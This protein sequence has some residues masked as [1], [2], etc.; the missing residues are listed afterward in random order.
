MDRFDKMVARFFSIALGLFLH[1]WVAGGS[2]L[3]AQ[4]PPGEDWR[5]LD[6]PHFRVTFPEGLLPLAQRAAARA[7]TAWEAL[8]EEFLEAPDGTI[9]LLL[10]DHIDVSNGFTQIFPSNR[11]VI[12]A[13]PPV[14]GFGLP[15]MDEWL[16]LVITH[17]LAHVFHEDRVR[18]LGSILRT[19]MGRVPLEW[20]FFPGAATPGWVVEGLATYY[21]SALTDAGRVRGSFH[22][23]VVRTAILENKFE[24]IDQSSGDSPEW[25]GG[26]RY[27]VYGSLFLTHLMD[28]F[29]PETM[30]VFADAVAGQWIPYRLNAAAQEAFGIPFTQAWDEWEA[31]LQERY[32]DL[33]RSLESQAPLTFGEALTDEGYYAWSP[34]PNPQGSGFAFAR[35][36][37]RSDS[38]VRFRDRATGRETKLVRTN[39]LSQ[40]S[41]TPSGELLF[42]QLEFTDSYRIR[43]DLF[44]RDRTGAV[45]QLTKGQR[46]DH[47]DVA[48]DGTRAVAVQEG[49][50]TNRL[51]LV[52]L[53]TGEVQPL[54]DFQEQVLW[55]YPRWS[56]D[57]K[58]LA[59][60][61]WKAGAYF[62]LVILSPD[63]TIQTEVTTD[64]AIDNGAAWSPDGRWLLWSSDRTGI[65][66]LFAVSIPGQGGGP[67]PVRQVTNVLGGAAY[68]S[69]DSEGR[70]IYFSAYHADGWRIERIPFDPGAWFDPFAL[71]AAFDTRPS[72]SRLEARAEGEARP[73]SPL[74]TLRPTFWAPTFREGD[75]AG[76][77]RVL[78]PG[79]GIFT[80]GE[81]LVGR[82]RYSASA[83][84]AG[85]EGSLNGRFSYAYGGLE[86]PVLSIAAAQSHDAGSRPLGGITEAGDTVPLFLVERE[87]ALGIGAAF[88]RKRTRNETVLSLSASHVWESRFLLENDLRRSSRFA[89]HRSEVRLGEARA[90]LSFGTARRF[91]LS[92]S[93]EDGIGLVIRGRLRR[94]LTLTD[95][96]RDVRGWDRSYQ[97]VVAQFVAFKGIPGPGFGN[98]VLALRGA[99]GLA[100]GPG[101]DAFHFETGGASG[102]TMPI[103]FV[104]VGQSLLFPIRGYETASRFGRRA[105]TV[106]AE[107]RFPLAMLNRGAGLFPLHLDWMA[108][109][110]FFDAGN[111]WGPDLSVA[112]F[113]N[114]K[115]DA[116]ASVGGEVVVRVLPL[117]FQSLDLRLGLARPLVEADE[118]TAYLRLGL[119]F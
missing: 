47:P 46:L 8:S 112:G 7:E 6:T 60:S 72:V 117:W 51:V 57:G 56:P 28:R 1:F 37:G 98:H 45:R 29:G 93:P 85:G 88:F 52:S 66:N 9:D 34:E 119:S 41:W 77:V 95:S 70:W 16:E 15:H 99:A 102:S 12:Y 106:A 83:T 100:G 78:E 2:A 76:D 19:L 116:L 105:W 14:D 30:G 54:I 115:R 10:T 80:S 23:M 107:Y 75:H 90:T 89:L 111:A 25:P 79:Y 114:P 110:L 61:R 24:R 22:E 59:V 27:Y 21:E 44:L 109:T 33:R 74:P 63:G 73:Y 36:D 94:D 86:N 35:Q 108:G 62:D 26:Q 50:G 97:D 104:D 4:V 87:R 65:P 5:T 68:P 11:I 31:E 101:A 53:S 82:H 48:P 38:Q 55:A 118:P 39:N 113:Q 3:E 96:L 92:L 58:H 91:P 40:F 18:N 67:G 84:V 17:E 69:V 20:P 81:D 103:D 49:G 32:G 13:P 43:G 64:R 42:S 71:H